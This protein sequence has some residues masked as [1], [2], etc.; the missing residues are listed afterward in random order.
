MGNDMVI[1]GDDETFDWWTPPDVL[2]ALGVVFDLDPCAPPLPAAPWLPE[3]RYS[4]PQDG[5]SLPWEGRVWLNPPYGP[6][7]VDWLRRLAQH[8]DGV[9]LV[10]ARTDTAWWHEVVPCATAV[11]FVSG[12][13]A[14]IR[15][16]AEMRSG[17][18][19]APSALLAFGD[20][21][22]DAVETS[23]LGMTFRSGSLSVGQGSLFG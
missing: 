20:E 6:R 5:L 16:G 23:K 17:N 8:G 7:T 15:E 10:F 9:A 14:F 11:T 1:R 19:G 12:R 3:R 22:A 2:R 21:C 18:S 13:L 4:L